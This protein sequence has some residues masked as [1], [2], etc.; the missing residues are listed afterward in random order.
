MDPIELDTFL[1]GT[2]LANYDLISDIDSLIESMH[3]N[4]HDCDTR[5]Y[6]ILVVSVS[7]PKAFTLFSSMQSSESWK[8]T[9]LIILRD[10]KND[11]KEVQRVYP[12]AKGHNMSLPRP[13]CRPSLKNVPVGEVLKAPLRAKKRWTKVCFTHMELGPLYSTF[14]PVKVCCW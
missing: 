11:W 1:Q 6:D 5:K 8:E 2:K 7:A 13:G 3:R 12:I 14:C 10:G 4:K 9:D